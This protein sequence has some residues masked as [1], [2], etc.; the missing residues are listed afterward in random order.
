MD[1]PSLFWLARGDSNFVYAACG[2]IGLRS[3]TEEASSSSSSSSSSVS[4]SCH[5]T[6]DVTV[7]FGERD[8]D[9]YKGV[10]EDSYGSGDPGEEDFNY[11]DDEHIL[12]GYPGDGGRSGFIKFDLEELDSSIVSQDQIKSARLYT[13]IGT[14]DITNDGILKVH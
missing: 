9:D 7:T 1:S 4:S 2:S 13:A 3:Y 5:F 12:I 8:A 14:N 10:T 6:T 11:G